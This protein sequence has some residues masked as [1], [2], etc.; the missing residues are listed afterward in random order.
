MA[1]RME[2]PDLI[3]SETTNECESVRQTSPLTVDEEQSR[4]K[5]LCTARYLNLCTLGK[6]DNA[7]TP[8]LRY[9]SP[10]NIFKLGCQENGAMVEIVYFWSSFLEI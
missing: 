8:C 10:E 3:F 2:R 5:Y 7:S 4:I 6:I 1:L 9:Q